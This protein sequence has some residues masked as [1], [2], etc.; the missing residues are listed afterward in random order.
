MGGRNV[1]V[2]SSSLPISYMTA[3]GNAVFFATLSQDMSGTA[4]Y[5][6]DGT[7]NGTVMVIDTDQGLQPSPQGPGTINCSRK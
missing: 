2:G 4:L 5:R 7:T 1:T 3:L 6:S